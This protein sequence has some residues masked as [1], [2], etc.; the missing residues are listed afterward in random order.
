M[1]ADYYYFHKKILNFAT[2]EKW[3]ESSKHLLIKKQY[4]FECRWECGCALIKY[5]HSAV[6]KTED[7]ESL[8]NV[9]S[10]CNL[11]LFTID[12]ILMEDFTK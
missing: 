8:K 11:H 9:K 4:F 6:T 3:N 12:F 7:T 2:L 1:I 5:G 10:M